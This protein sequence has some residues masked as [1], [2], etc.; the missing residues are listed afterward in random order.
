MV[1]SIRPMHFGEQ[2]ETEIRNSGIS[3]KELARRVAEITSADPESVRRLI[4]KHLHGEVTPG[5]GM[6]AAYERALGLPP[7][8]FGRKPDPGAIKTERL[9]KALMSH[10]QSRYSN[11]K[12]PA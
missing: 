2:L 4:Y 1:L 5:P 10:L 12:V 6:R 9:M 7:D 8:F 11:P 3:L